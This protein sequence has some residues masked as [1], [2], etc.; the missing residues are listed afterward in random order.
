MSN[1]NVEG[2]F[3]MSDAEK[4]EVQRYLFVYAQKVKMNFNRN[5]AAKE[6]EWNIFEISNMILEGWLEDEEF[7]LAQAMKDTIIN[8]EFERYMDN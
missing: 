2:Y 5:R 7:E 3:G 6:P 8:Y 1:L 4:L